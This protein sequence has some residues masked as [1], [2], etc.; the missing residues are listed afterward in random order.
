MIRVTWAMFWMVSSDVLNQNCDKPV[1]VVLLKKGWNYKLYY[2]MKVKWHYESAFD[3]CFGVLHLTL[4]IKAS[5]YKITQD[6]TI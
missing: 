5:A 4:V 3:I 6:Y 1:M 2:L